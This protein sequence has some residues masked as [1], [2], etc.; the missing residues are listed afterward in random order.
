MN[1]SQISS[2]GMEQLKN[3]TKNSVN[4]KEPQTEKKAGL[5]S[6][7]AQSKKS[8]KSNKAELMSSLKNSEKPSKPNSRNKSDSP[9][10]NE[11][12]KM[13]S[14]F[15]NKVNKN[16]M[17]EADL[18]KII[19]ALEERIMAMTAQQKI[20]LKEFS[21][22]KEKGIENTK[23]MKDTLMKMFANEAKRDQLF[24]FLKNPDFLSLLMS[25]PNKPDTYTPSTVKENIVAQD[26]ASSKSTNPVKPQPP[27]N[28]NVS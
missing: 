1:T 20:K 27:K 3:A 16:E 17:G 12:M 21:V 19:S 11:Y 8:N 23:G 2:S 24:D 7:T 28:I 13:I 4:R 26:K 9:E 5:E 10:I 18:G 25:N 14:R 22:F 15:E 6:S